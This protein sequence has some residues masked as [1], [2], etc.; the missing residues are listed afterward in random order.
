MVGGDPISRKKTLRN[1][2]MAPYH[3]DIVGQAHTFGINM[4]R[5]IGTDPIQVITEAISG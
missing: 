4:S 5:Q 2:S 3:I 1:T